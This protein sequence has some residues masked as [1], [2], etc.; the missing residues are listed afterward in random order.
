MSRPAGPRNDAEARD[1]LRLVR[2]ENVGPATFFSLLERYGTA[3][4]ALDALPEIAERGGLRR[5]LKRATADM[6]AREMDRAARIGARHV[7]IGS[8]DYPARL[9]A[10]HSPP[11]VITVRGDAALLSRRPLAIVGSRKAS[12]GGRT[13]ARDFAAAFGEAGRAVVSGLA[14]GIDAAAHRGALAAGTVA[15]VAGGVDRPT[16][17]EHIP[18]ADEIIAN[19]GAVA[20]EMPL[21]MQPFARDYP[22]RN[23]L[24]AGLSDAVVIVEAALRSGSLHTARFAADENRDI[25]AVP[26]SPLDPRAAGCLSLLREGAA[27]AIEPRDILDSVATWEAEPML[28]GFQEDGAPAPLAV[29]S[30]AVLAAVAEAL[31]LSPVSVDQIARA[32]DIAVGTVT[33][34]IVE[35][36]IAGRAEREPN[37]SVRAALPPD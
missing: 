24:I 37:G 23:R 11:P 25:F 29:P 32:T 8:P 36:E 10:I 35:L 1:W 14:L 5:P 26:G 22:R 33:A 28:P 16:P 19:G 17:E 31:S 30:T 12:A 6:V 3:A 9:A 7:F 21:G 13:L 27:M 2:S 18:L 4:A 15:V 34:A 20:S